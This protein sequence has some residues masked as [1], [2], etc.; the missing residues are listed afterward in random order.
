[1]ASSYIHRCI[2]LALDPATDHSLN[3]VFLSA[4]LETIGWS[5][6]TPGLPTLHAQLSLSSASVGSI[7]ALISV[8][9]LL[10]VVVQGMASDAMGR[11][12]LLSISSLAQ[13]LGHVVLYYFALGH[14]TSIPLFIT[15]RVLPSIFKCGMI[16]SQA[17]VCDCIYNN[18]T[19]AEETGLNAQQVTTKHIS[20]LM[21]YTNLGFIIGPILGGQLSAMDPSYPFSAGCGVFLLNLLLLTQTKDPPR[22]DGAVGTPSSKRDDDCEGGQGPG[23]QGPGHV[24]SSPSSQ[25]PYSSQSS[26]SSSSSSYYR[27]PLPNPYHHYHHSALQSK[28]SIRPRRINPAS[29]HYYGGEFQ[30]YLSSSLPSSEA[31]KGHGCGGR[32]GLDPVL[33]SLS[34]LLHIKF[35]FQVGNALYESLFAQHLKDRIGTS[36]QDLGWLLGWC[37]LEAAF[38]NGVWVRFVLAAPG[39][40][41]PTLVFSALLQG[42]G[43]AMWAYCHS[44]LYA[45]AGAALIALSSNTFLSLIQGLIARHSDSASAARD[46]GPEAASGSSKGASGAGRTFGLSTSVDRAA[47]TVA[48]ILGALA[49]QHA[50]IL[51]FSLCAASTGVYT[52]AAISVWLTFYGG[53]TVG[54]SNTG[55]GHMD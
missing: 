24:A 20:T 8:I 5:I 49:L 29:A 32:A 19:T 34:W 27:K 46:A 12:K 17:Y 31:S 38:V 9:A 54:T 26:S 37:G 33:P 47:R 55:N 28:S 36:A 45:A 25:S 2:S 23:H 50:G 21:A 51:G 16:V 10:S 40:T 6:I 3:K 18:P 14:L 11:V 41:W 1:M 53:S 39:R 15:F 52:A 7:S 13:L 35:A 48:P 43:L 42:L 44:F 30:P 22:N 4:A